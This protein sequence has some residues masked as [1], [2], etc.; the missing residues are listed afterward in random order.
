MSP[1]LRAR[2]IVEDRWLTVGVDEPIDPAADV[3]V[4][5]ARW[6]KER[7]S[8]LSRPGRTGVLFAPADD[9]AAIGGELDRLSV[10][11][12]EFPHFTDGRG[13]S[14]ARLLRERYGYHGELRA[15]GDVQ[16]DQVYYLKRVGFDTFLLRP[17]RDAADAAEAADDFSEAYQSAVD[18]PN[19]LFRRRGFPPPRQPTS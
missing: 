11:A 6:Q 1:L 16:R 2:A 19:P 10:I 13:Y 15:V 7:A 14:T 8:L 3:I 5:L 4:P 12:V 9:P 17:D 18:R